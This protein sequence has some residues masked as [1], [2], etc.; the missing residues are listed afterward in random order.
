MTL[1]I[2]N[3]FHLILFADDRSL[4]NKTETLNESGI[5]NELDKLCLCPKLNKLCLN[6]GKTE[7][8]TLPLPT[9][10]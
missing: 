5:N 2:L 9:S 8:L 4:V 6:I 1:Q 10:P 7:G 3:V